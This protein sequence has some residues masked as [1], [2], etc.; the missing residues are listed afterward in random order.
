MKLNVRAF[1]VALSIWWGVG[2]FLGTWWVIAMSGATGEPTFL[3]RLYIGYEISPLGSVIGL[4]W[5]VVDAL[6]AGAI[7]AWLYNTI[8]ERFFAA[9]EPQAQV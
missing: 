2:I 6:I 4:V 9:K 7:F 1:A 3:A 8:A 5:G